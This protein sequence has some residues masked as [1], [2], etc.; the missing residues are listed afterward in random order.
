MRL[1]LVFF[2]LFTLF[3]NAPFSLKAAWD[4]DSL[5]WKDLSAPEITSGRQC[6][7]MPHKIHKKYAEV[8]SNFKTLN[9]CEIY[10]EKAKIY[11]IFNPWEGAISQIVPAEV[12]SSSDCL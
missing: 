3:C 12:C 8:K 4:V 10:I 11:N 9:N 2:S 6:P 7:A 1:P 5:D